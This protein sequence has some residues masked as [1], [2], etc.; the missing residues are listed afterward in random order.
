MSSP[1]AVYGDEQSVGLSVKAY[2]QFAKHMPTPT[3]TVT[4]TVLSKTIC[5]VTLKSG[6]GSCRLSARELALGTYHLVATY[7]GN[8]SYLGSSKA[9]K[10]VVV[11]TRPTVS[12]LHLSHPTVTYGH[13]QLAR[14]SVVTLSLRTGTPTGT[15][16]ITE[17]SKV[18]C[19]IALFDDTGS[20]RLSPRQLGVGTHTLVASYPGNPM[21]LPSVATAK[22]TVV[23]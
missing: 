21:Y 19:R 6:I 2:V 23:A 3:G 5:T 10:L 16:T 11:K 1:T 13:E 15:V 14:L 4:I 9:K 18:I 8:G 20:C 22:L 17:G 12:T 7:S